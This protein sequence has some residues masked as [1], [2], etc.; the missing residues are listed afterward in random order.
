MS[1]QFLLILLS[2]LLSSFLNGSKSYNLKKKIN[3]H[4]KHIH[5]WDNDIN[6]DI[7]HWYICVE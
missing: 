5:I 4:V 6:I 1:R 3:K 7:L 2:N